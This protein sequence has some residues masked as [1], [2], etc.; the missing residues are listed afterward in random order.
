MA[1]M[2]HSMI[3]VKDADR[4]IQ[5]YHDV[6]ALR[7]KRRVDFN[8]FSLIY[9]ANDE[10]SFELELTWNHKGDQTYD[11]GNGYGHLAFA[12]DDLKP[13]HQ[14]AAE[15]GYQPREIK[16]FYNGDELVAKFFFIQ[17]PDGYE[18]EVIERSA[19]YG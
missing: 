5:F 16:S 3:R 11:L 7:V 12:A 8:D 10:T 13:L 6:F 19:V 15:L 14:Q 2:I 4:S 9:L 18:I 17:D 1:K